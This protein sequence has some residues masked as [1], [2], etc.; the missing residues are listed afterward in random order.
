MCKNCEYL[1]F[2]VQFFKANCDIILVTMVTLGLHK[3]PED[4][5]FSFWKYLKN[6]VG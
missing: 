3:N 4:L 6:Q 1:Y 2:A 5:N